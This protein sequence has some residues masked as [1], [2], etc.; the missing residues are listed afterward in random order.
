MCFREQTID[1][2]VQEL[3]E[4]NEEVL[5]V[6]GPVYSYILDDTFDTFL[7][8]YQ[9]ATVARA[10]AYGN[11]QTA[12]ES[13]KAVNTAAINAKYSHTAAMNNEINTAKTTNENTRKE[14]DKQTDKEY[15][16]AES[17]S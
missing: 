4:A 8:Y 7:E 3:D 12:A 6:A 1:E 2:R 9:D 15:N 16:N 5:Q 17:E 13:A 11:L 10:E 14:T